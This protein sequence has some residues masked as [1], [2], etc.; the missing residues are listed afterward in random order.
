MLEYSSDPELKLDDVE[1]N[2]LVVNEQN[3][4]I[5]VLAN[6]STGERFID[7]P[8]RGRMKCRVPNLP[9]V[10]GDYG[11]Q[12]SCLVR[13]ELVD[14]V[15]YAAKFTVVEG[16]FFGTGILPGKSYGDVLVSHNWS[17]ESHPFLEY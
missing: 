1:I 7:L 11:I 10:P 6:K 13:G 15:L 16:D 3:N 5:F 8:H 14:K 17:A 9:L 4:R 12:F 2:L